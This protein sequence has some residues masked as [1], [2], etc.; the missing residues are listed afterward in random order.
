MEELT[1]WARRNNLTQNEFIK[2][3]LTCAVA[4]GSK[5][6]DEQGDG[7]GLIYRARDSVGE[8][9]LTVKRVGE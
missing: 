6:I 3:I 2:E 4:I 5:E 9:I 1:T 8:I 7:K